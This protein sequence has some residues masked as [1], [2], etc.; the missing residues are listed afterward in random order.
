VPHQSRLGDFRREPVRVLHVINQLSARAGAEV[1]LR[2]IIEGSL[3]DGIEHGVVVLKPEP[4]EAAGFSRAVPLYA[5]H[6][7]GGRVAQ[8]RRTSSAIDDFEPD[9]VHTSLFEADLIGRLAAIRHRIPVLTSLVN[10]PYDPEAMQTEPVARWKIAA[11]R[12]VDRL[13]A[14]RATTAFHAISRATADHAT[15]QLHVDP[16]AIRIVPRGR[17]ADRLGERTAARR[18]TV[19]TRLGWDE[20]PVIVNVA[21]QEPQKGHALLVEAM[22]TVLQRH[23]A[24]KLMLV[25]RDGRA[26]G[27]LRSRIAE[28][29]IE[30]SVVELGERD[31]VPDMLA[32]ADV[33]AF[34]SLY[35]GLGGAVVEATGLGVPV[36][37]FDVPAVREV[38]GDDHP[39]LVPIGDT[40]ALG[41][42]IADVLVGGEEVERVA[43]RER[44]RFLTYYEL[45]RC[46]REMVSLYRDIVTATR[47]GDGRRGLRP[48]VIDVRG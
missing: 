9:I 46:V 11:V 1:S 15:R 4:A 36:V 22:V 35:E 7:V 31:D 10:T 42:V 28:L 48:Q 24:A 18:S 43:A 6:G 20:G 26:T 14:R 39:W 23:P 47:L 29:G 8:V 34:S 25:G 30:G 17:S 33:F 21:R 41:Q 38:L 5:P 13:L 32:A 16:Q 19:R 2:D 40:H 45:D 37:S 3:A 44:E 12:Y 27:H